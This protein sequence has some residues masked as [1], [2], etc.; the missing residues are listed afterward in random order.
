[1][2]IAKG[3]LWCYEK[4]ICRNENVRLYC[5]RVNERDSFKYAGL[6]KEI[7]FKKSRIGLN[8]VTDK[9]QI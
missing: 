3:I 2:V 9:F 6:T 4:C 7:E 1:M 8:W 5:I